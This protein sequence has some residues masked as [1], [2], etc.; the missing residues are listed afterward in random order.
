MEA[1][2]MVIPLKPGPLILHSTPVFNIEIIQSKYSV[3]ARVTTGNTPPLLANI[4]QG[5]GAVNTGLKP[6]NAVQYAV[7]SKGRLLNDKLSYKLA[8]FDLEITDRLAVQHKNG[9]S[10]TTNVGKQQNEGV[11]FFLG[12]NIIQK[13]SAPVSN[14]KVQL[15]YTYSHFRYNEFKT[16]KKITQ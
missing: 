12:Y 6:E 4:I 3:Y 9:T 7:G 13:V 15:S 11:E 5:N 2:I 1:S 14:L 16:F 10:Y 8:L